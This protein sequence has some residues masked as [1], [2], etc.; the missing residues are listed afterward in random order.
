MKP[1]AGV[2]AT[3][4]RQSPTAVTARHRRTQSYPIPRD[5]CARLYRPKRSVIHIL[6]TDHAHHHSRRLYR[7]PLIGASRLP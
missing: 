7:R 6:E 3:P 2:L 1:S 5:S 4:R